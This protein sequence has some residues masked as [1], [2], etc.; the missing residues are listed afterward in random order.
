MRMRVEGMRGQAVAMPGARPTPKSIRPGAMASSTRNCSATL[1][2]GIVRQHDAGAAARECAGWWRRLPQSEFP[3]PCRRC[4]RCCDAPRP[5]SAHSP[6]H[7]NVAPERWIRG[8]QHPECCPRTRETDRVR[9]ISS[10]EVD[11]ILAAA[12]SEHGRNFARIRIV[13]ALQTL[14]SRPAGPPQAGFGSPS[15]CRTISRSKIR[16]RQSCA[17]FY[18]CRPRGASPIFQGSRRD[19]SWVAV[20]PATKPCSHSMSLMNRS[21]PLACTTA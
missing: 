6:I 21:V 19:A 18:R 5:S 2:G 1:S 8:S 7:R 17:A 15:T 4:W 16:N 13:R 3:A 12:G 20:K 11:T 10:G 14:H 9:T